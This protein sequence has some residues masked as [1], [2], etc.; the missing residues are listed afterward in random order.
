M[1]AGFGPRRAFYLREVVARFQLME[2]PTEEAYIADERTPFR[3]MDGGVI[4]RQIRYV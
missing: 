4:E 2:Y 1:A 3:E